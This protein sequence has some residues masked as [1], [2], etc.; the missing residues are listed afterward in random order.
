[1]K[2]FQIINNHNSKHAM[3]GSDTTEKI[4]NHLIEIVAFEFR[5]THYFSLLSPF[6]TK[7]GI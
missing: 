2:N 3:Y 6:K 1:M 7:K 4:V 5:H